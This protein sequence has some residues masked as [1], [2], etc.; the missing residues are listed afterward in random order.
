MVLFRWP[1]DYALLGKVNVDVAML[2]LISLLSLIGLVCDVIRL[3]DS[4]KA[5]PKDILDQN[6]YLSRVSILL[7][8]PEGYSEAGVAFRKGLLGPLVLTSSANLIM[9]FSAGSLAIRQYDYHYI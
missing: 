3:V 2:S 9:V 5:E 1:F 4:I 8:D 7:G 6:P